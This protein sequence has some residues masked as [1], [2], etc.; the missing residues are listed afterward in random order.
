MSGFAL[1]TAVLVHTAL[2]HGKMLWRGMRNAKTEEDD[3]HAKFMRRYPEVPEWW[4]AAIGISMFV[5][6]VITIEVSLKAGQE[7]T[8]LSYFYL[9][10]FTTQACQ[11]GLC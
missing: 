10:R 7:R 2:Y 5:L 3:I 9:F 1:I 8:S 11:F 6:A 4:Y